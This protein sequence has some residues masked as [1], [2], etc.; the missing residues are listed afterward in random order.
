MAA[1][2]G[3]FASNRFAAWRHS[4]WWWWLVLWLSIA[5]VH[6]S[7]YGIIARRRCTGATCGGVRWQTEAFMPSLTLKSSSMP[8][9][10]GAH[11]QDNDGRRPLIARREPQPCRIVNSPSCE[12]SKRFKSGR[13]MTA[14]TTILLLLLACGDDDDDDDSH[15]RHQLKRV[16]L[17]CKHGCYV[18][19]YT[20]LLSI[21]HSIK[22]HLA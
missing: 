15:V 18:R 1:T 22:H 10:D 4:G 3:R 11:H 9:S 14:M 7:R 17:R 19:F 8:R 6:T 13:C 21:K 5:R 12:R 16:Y 20:T 2:L